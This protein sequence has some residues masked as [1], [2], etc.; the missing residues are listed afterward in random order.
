MFLFFMARTIGK[1]CLLYNFILFINS[2]GSYQY[3]RTKH[4]CMLGYKI[5]V[6]H[7]TNYLS[8]IEISYLADTYPLMG[9]ILKKISNYWS[10]YKWVFSKPGHNCMLPIDVID[11]ILN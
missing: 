2:I 7:Y 3:D 4:N 5:L 9:V 11:S 6:I 8:N 10:Y 1:T